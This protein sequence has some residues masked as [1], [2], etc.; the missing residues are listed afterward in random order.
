MLI[1]HGGILCYSAKEDA[2]GQSVVAQFWL[3]EDKHQ[4]TRAWFRQHDDRTAPT[5]MMRLE[6]FQMAKS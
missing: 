5:L 3:S 1:I 6:G 2:E 4:Q